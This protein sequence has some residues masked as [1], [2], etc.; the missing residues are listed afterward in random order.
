MAM[1]CPLKQLHLAAICI[2]IIMASIYSHAQEKKADP[3][4]KK[5]ASLLRVTTRS[6]KVYV[7]QVIENGKLV[8]KFLDLVSNEPVEIAKSDVKEV[9][10][11]LPF[12]DAV[13][14]IGLPR[15]LSWKIGLLA[16][17]MS[18]SGKVAKVTSQV[19]YVTLGS[20]SGVRVGTMLSVYRNHGEIKD[21]T[22]GAVLGIERPMISSL[23]VTE[24]EENFSKA[25]I[26]S[27]LEIPIQVGDE[28][29]SKVGLVIAVCP[30]R[31]EDG[32]LTS[33][34]S[35]MSEE[36]TTSLV[37]ASIKVVERSVLAT[38]LPELIAQNTIL[39][40]PKSA[41]RLGELTGANYVVTGKI[42]P[43]RNTGTAFVRLV[44]VQSA[45]V[46]LAVSTNINLKNTSVVQGKPA[47]SQP[48]GPSASG[49]P[50]SSGKSTSS[51]R[52]SSGSFKDG[53]LPSFLTSSTRISKAKS[54]IT[55]A[56]GGVIRTKDVNFLD[57]DFTFE[58]LLDNS[59]GGAH[60][61]IGTRDTVQLQLHTTAVGNNRGE[62][63]L[64]ESI[65]GNISS[66][67]AHLLRI[68]KKGDTVTFQ[69]D[70]DN[71]GLSD[72]DLETIIPNIREHAPSFHSKNVPLFLS[73]KAEFISASL[74]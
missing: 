43:N 40:D 34:G 35:T 2:F 6:S 27:N 65:I 46:A 17:K 19:V 5:E 3:P 71:D 72:D 26:N 16:K 52:P 68:Q 36:I 31:N 13:K 14:S 42:V 73:G 23:V 11:P 63:K 62:V 67:G 33:V 22:T 8:V 1:S 47:N 21:P 70:V 18:N 20:S 58:V 41:Q 44:D 39:F 12:D 55:I 57:R 29:E 50:S 45:E 53:R 28:V 10:N 48:A 54:G 38:V 37:Q 7:G 15:L 59:T 74:K 64:N 61:G 51:T 4:E 24:V 69:I 66:T 25:K 56:D 32:E 9:V 30:L 60:V 49:S